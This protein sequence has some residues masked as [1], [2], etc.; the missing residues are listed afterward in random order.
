MKVKISTD[1][2]KS[3]NK[4]GNKSK[5]SQMGLYETKKLLHSKGNNQHTK[6]TNYRMG[7]NIYKLYI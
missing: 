6:E 1:N 7:E 2:N 3:K 5:N 4:Q